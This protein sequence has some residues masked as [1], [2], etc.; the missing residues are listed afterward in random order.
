[1]GFS[2]IFGLGLILLS[3]LIWTDV[4]QLYITGPSK[5]IIPSILL[6][7]GIVLPIFSICIF[8]VVPFILK[9]AKPTVVKKMKSVL[10]KSKTKQPYLHFKDEEVN[11]PV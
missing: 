3:I 7:L 8:I 6:S 4:V 11:T 10:P 5:H 9:K 2:G 1:M